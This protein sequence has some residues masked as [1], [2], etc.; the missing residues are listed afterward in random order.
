MIWN[1]GTPDELNSAINAAAPGDIISLASGNYG[2]LFIGNKN[3]SS[4]LM[5]VSADVSDPAVF[6]TIKITACSGLTID[7]V[8]VNMVPDE[9]TKMW[10]TAVSISESSD[11]S[12]LN[13][14][15]EAGNSVAG[16][17]PDSPAGA[18]DGS[19]VLGYPIGIGIGVGNSEDI[20]LS[21]N[22][23]SNVGAGVKFGNV[24]GIVASGNEIHDIRLSPFA[25]ADVD[26][27]IIEENIVYNIEPW[28]YGG[29]GD[30]ADYVHFWTNSDQVD[31]NENIII[32]SN[33][34]LQGDGLPIIG[35]L[36]RDKFDK[37]YQ[38]VTIE[39][40]LFHLG[41]KQA[42]SLENVVGATV[43]DNTFIAS[44]GTPK[45]EPGVFLYGGTRDV[46]AENNVL[47]GTGIYGSSVD[48]A[49]QLNIQLTG[50]VE[51]QSQYASLESYAGNFF[52][53]PYTTDVDLSNFKVVEG[54]VVDGLG[55]SLT[56]ITGSPD[57]DGTD[58]T[59]GPDD[60]AGDAIVIDEEPTTD[61]GV[62]DEPD[63]VEFT[64][65]V[66]ATNAD[67]WNNDE[68]VEELISDPRASGD[69]AGM[70]AT[71]ESLDP[72]QFEDDGG[73]TTG[74]EAS[75]PETSS[76]T[77]ATSPSDTDQGNDSS[78]HGLSGALEK[79]L[80]LFGLQSQPAMTG[81]GATAELDPSPLNE[82][83]AMK[84]NVLDE[85]APQG[86]KWFWQLEQHGEVDHSDVEDGTELIA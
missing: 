54:T 69:V 40:N 65:G 11:I 66:L 60:T 75:V 44:S 77:S 15:I 30:H 85:F 83:P 53:N 50:N 78:S 57:Q 34:F 58:S 27:I 73:A 84:N 70:S 80:T 26:N 64:Y 16:I 28:K 10:S 74:A 31:G 41:N 51:L 32:R 20:F 21:G 86:R 47:A 79:L 18:Q 33:A 81:S 37:P 24:D 72:V 3:F 59:S 1:V 19:G 38:N 29:N 52:Q 63:G 61:A 25:G 22:E 39:D 36:F 71:G 17:S 9:N 48:N 43:S 62:A 45:D 12:V 82:A 42:V 5:I 46:I 13:S 55:S 2:D 49:A 7:S 68:I 56:Q 6:D 14:T 23:V 35:L 8:S 67:D 76:E 4:D